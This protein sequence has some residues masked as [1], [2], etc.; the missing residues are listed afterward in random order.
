MI[1]SA[2]SDATL[3]ATYA[4][5]LA[6]VGT[7]NY[8]RVTLLIKYT[9]AASTRVC[10]V[11]VEVSDEQA[12]FYSDTVLIDSDGTGNSNA[13]V[14][15][16]TIDGA[17]GGTAETRVLYFNV[18]HQYMRVSAKEDGAATFGTLHIKIIRNE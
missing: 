16:H 10:T 18:A 7:A 9:P 4:G 6:T 12:Q 3:T 17:T 2:T 1:G 11:Q 15:L 8:E 13:K 14:Q 5:N